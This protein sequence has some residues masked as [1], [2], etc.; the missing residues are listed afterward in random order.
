MSTPRSFN[1]QGRMFSIPFCIRL[2]FLT[3]QGRFVAPTISAV[4]RR[5]SPSSV[6][7][8]GP[9]WCDVSLQPPASLCVAG[10]TGNTCPKSRKRTYSGLGRSV[11]GWPLRNSPPIH[12]CHTGCARR[13]VDIPSDTSLTDCL[14]HANKRRRIACAAEQPHSQDVA[15][16]VSKTVHSRFE[17]NGEAASVPFSSGRWRRLGASMIPRSACV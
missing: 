15:A 1:L 10:V 5:S 11:K 17:L 13:E 6:R 3:S 8:P 14:R 4:D 12:R 2:V 9:P 7:A 16:V